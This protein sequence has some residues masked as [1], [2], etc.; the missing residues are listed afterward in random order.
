MRGDEGIA[1]Y[2]YIYKLY[3]KLQFRIPAYNR[4]A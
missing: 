2:E 1:P 3:A 4:K